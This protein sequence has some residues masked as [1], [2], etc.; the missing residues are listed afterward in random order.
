MTG[1]ASLAGAEEAPAGADGATHEVIT[2]DRDRRLSESIIWK[3]QRAYY[4]RQGPAAWATGTVPSYVTSN[5]AVAR[6][7]ADLLFG[8]L[9]DWHRSGELDLSQP[10]NVVE[11]GSGAGKFGFL[12]A[13]RFFSLHRESRLAA[14]PVRLVLTDLAGANV[15]F[16]RQHPK[17]AP[18]VSEGLVDFAR[19]DVE[20]D[21]SLELTESGELLSSETVANP[22]GAI[23]NYVLDSIPQDAFAVVAGRLHESL[24]TVHAVDLP[25]NPDDAEAMGHLRLEYRRR[26]VEAAGYYGVRAWDAVLAE[27]EETLPDTAFVFPRAA[28]AC[29]ERLRAL[30]GGR[31]LFVSGDMGHATHADLIGRDEPGLNVHGSFSLLVNHHALA[32]VCERS[33]GAAL[34]APHQ[35]VA[36]H[37]AALLYGGPGDGYPEARQAF[38]TAIC[39]HG[40]DDA[41]SVAKSVQ[42][43]HHD[44][45]LD[46]LAAHLRAAGHDPKLLLG[47]FEPLATKVPDAPESA[48]EELRAI[49]LATWDHHYELGPMPDVAFCVG[50]LLLGLGFPQ[51][52]AGFLE[53]SLVRRGPHPAT[54]VNLA[55]ARLRV[56]DEPG[57]RAA[58]SA[59]RALDPRY[60]PARSLAVALDDPDAGYAAR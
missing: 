41:F 21:D 38:R 1:L 45:P 55:Q 50:A 29:V 23:A 5:P 56:G 11:L 20:H 3:L 10:V 32:A 46:E 47:A 37:V 44:M 4:E 2:L 59:A 9:R 48:R 53:E 35:P 26:E 28:L 52:A 40:P 57:A 34:Q 17:L 33:G 8:W 16:W 6:A 39:E 14:V 24:V 19:F 49:L 51:E 12:L 42:R 13:K 25:E 30:G 31:L 18:F 58:V 36:L 60:G 43:A 15:D 22:V 7:Y 54:L 27:Y